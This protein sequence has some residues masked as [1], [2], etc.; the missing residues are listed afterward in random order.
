MSCGLCFL[1][2]Q[3]PNLRVAGAGGHHALALEDEVI[4]LDGNLVTNTAVDGVVLVLVRHVVGGG[5]TSVDLEEV[6][7]VGL[8]DDA[9]HLATDAAEAVDAGLHAHLGR[10]VASSALGSD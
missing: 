5:G 10:G 2:L 3:T 6:G 7:I 9:G 1:Q 8:D 4:T